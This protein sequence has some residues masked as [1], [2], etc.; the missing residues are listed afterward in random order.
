M[1]TKK[2]VKCGSTWTSALPACAFCGGE[3]EEMP[4]PAALKILSRPQPPPPPPPPPEPEPA[5]EP[6]AEIEDQAAV[7]TAPESEAPAPLP[8]PEPTPTPAPVVRQPPPPVAV[9]PSHKVSMVLGLV[10]LAA[11]AAIPLA[12]H[13]QAHKVLGFMGLILCA[14]LAPVPPAAWVAGVRYERRA[15]E[16]GLAPHPGGK[17]GRLIGLAA[18]FLVLLEVSATAVLVTVLRLQGKLPATFTGP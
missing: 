15:R 17:W 12:V 10:S 18:T 16:A 5:Q 6:E 1:A 7:A 3:A 9:G 11:C 14:L 2:C 13:F 4:D 8:E